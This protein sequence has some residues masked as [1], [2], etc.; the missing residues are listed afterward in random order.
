MLK[1]I[2]M[3][4]GG[5]LLCLLAYAVLALLLLLVLSAACAALCDLGMAIC[6]P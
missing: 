1:E 3:L 2:G 6:L 4:L 5:M